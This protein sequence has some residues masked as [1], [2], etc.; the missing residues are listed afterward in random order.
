MYSYEYMKQAFSESVDITLAK[1]DMDTITYK[2]YPDYKA[3]LNNK[4]KY[5]TDLFVK[6]AI[7]Y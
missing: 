4:I 2:K 5:F 7:F 3:V 1:F 6:N